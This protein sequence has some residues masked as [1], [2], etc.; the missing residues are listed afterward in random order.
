MYFLMYLHKH[1]FN[2]WLQKQSLYCF[3]QWFS[4]RGEGRWGHYCSRGTAGWL[5]EFSFFFICLYH[6]GGKSE[7]CNFIFFCENVDVGNNRISN[8]VQWSY[9][10]ITVKVGVKTI[11]KEE[12]LIYA[13]HQLT[14]WCHY[15]A[16]CFTNRKARKYSSV[17]S[18]YTFHK[19][20]KCVENATVYL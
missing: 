15:P 4:K 1:N 9:K 18:S 5:I 17:V 19:T 11:V 2:D 8:W 7:I 6:R 16:F 13:L 3:K 10:A 12:L 20:V 14:L